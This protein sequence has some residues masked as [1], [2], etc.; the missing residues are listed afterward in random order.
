MRA[1]IQGLLR[2]RAGAYAVADWSIDTT[3]RTVEE[4]VRAIIGYLE[5]KGY[6]DQERGN[7]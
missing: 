4:V 6:L 2:A 7:G 1:K 5:G 3:G